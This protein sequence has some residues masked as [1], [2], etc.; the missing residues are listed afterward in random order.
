MLLD[1]FEEQ[2]YLPTTAVKLGNGQ[3]GKIEIVGDEDEQFV[4]L[5]IV[6]LYPAQLDRVILTG[7]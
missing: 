5:G 1:P 3:G 6:E 7:L 2:F 4:V